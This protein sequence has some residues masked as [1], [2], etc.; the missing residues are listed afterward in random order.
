MYSVL[1]LRIVEYYE[2]VRRALDS[3]VETLIL[4]RQDNQDVIDDLN[5][6]RDSQI[7][8]LKQ[9][10]DD[11][12]NR[13]NQASSST[14]NEQEIIKWCYFTIPVRINKICLIRCDVSLSPEQIATYRQFL[15][16][17]VKGGESLKRPTQVPKLLEVFHVKFHHLVV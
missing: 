9:E 13:A 17:S 6:R 15:I 12:L 8:F 3:D 16:T 7:K 10:E 4:E 2:E 11:A 5:Q 1:R 14:C